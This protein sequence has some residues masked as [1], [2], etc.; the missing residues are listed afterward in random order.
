LSLTTDQR[1]AHLRYEIADNLIR[2]AVDD[3]YS[4]ARKSLEANGMDCASDD[5]AEALVAA[6]LIYLED[7]AVMLPTKGKA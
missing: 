5:R 6:I 3:A 2:Q 1:L 7:S 4:A